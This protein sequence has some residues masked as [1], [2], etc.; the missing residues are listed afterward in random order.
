MRHAQHS[1]HPDVHRDSGGL[2]ACPQ[3]LQA[4]G[5]RFRNGAYGSDRAAAGRGDSACAR[6][7]E[8]RDAQYVSRARAAVYDECTRDLSAAPELQGCSAGA[9]GRRSR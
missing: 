1:R 8:T 5:D 4:R 6:D 2:C 7:V 3:A 9:D